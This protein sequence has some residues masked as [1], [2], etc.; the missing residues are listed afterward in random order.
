MLSIAD[1]SDSLQNLILQY[2]SINTFLKHYLDRRI[3][4]DVAKIYRGM[5]LEKELMRFV[6]SIS[7][8]ID[9]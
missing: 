7:R 8:S 4:M 6:C 3:N 1:V 9:P 5:K 2:A